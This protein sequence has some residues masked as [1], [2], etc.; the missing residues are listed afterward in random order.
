MSLVCDL[1]HRWDRDDV[2]L[3]AIV[4]LRLTHKIVATSSFLRVVPLALTYKTPLYKGH[5]IPCRSKPWY[6]LAL[7]DLLLAR[8]TVTS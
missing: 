6:V 1:D 5:G 2:S 4:F 8:R 7:I 3:F